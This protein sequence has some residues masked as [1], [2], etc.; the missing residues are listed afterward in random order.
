M[1]KSR[2]F[3]FLFNFSNRFKITRDIYINDY[4]NGIFQKP[5]LSIHFVKLWIISSSLSFKNKILLN[6]SSNCG[7]I[8]GNLNQ[9]QSFFRF[10]DIIFTWQVSKNTLPLINKNC[11]RKIDWKKSWNSWNVNI[12]SPYKRYIFNL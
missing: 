5:I 4:L 10:L 6:K 11:F 12:W 9:Q 2:S 1:K 3:I 8:N 7:Q